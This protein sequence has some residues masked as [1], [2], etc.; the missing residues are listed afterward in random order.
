MARS[1][2][3]PIDF[4]YDGVVI[5]LN[6]NLPTFVNWFPRLFASLVKSFTRLVENFSFDM[7]FV[8]TFNVTCSGAQAPGQALT[9][10]V[11][12]SAIFLVF[13]MSLFEFMRVTFQGVSAAAPRYLQRLE[14]P[15]TSRFMALFLPGG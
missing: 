9:N 3:T 1:A 11:L 5:T 2:N 4:F 12:G 6:Y 15:N 10:V 7:V 13:E 8:K 14:R